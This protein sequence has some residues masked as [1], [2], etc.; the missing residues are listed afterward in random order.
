MRDRAFRPS[1]RALRTPIV[2]GGFNASLSWVRI[3]KSPPAIG[4]VFSKSPPV[5]NLGS[6]RKTTV[7][8]K[9]VP[10]KTPFLRLLGQ[11]PPQGL[12]SVSHEEI[13]C[14]VFVR[15]ASGLRLTSWSAF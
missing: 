11:E 7:F 5:A 8:G 1:A 2:E 15:H 4:F 9:L 10:Q 13:N 14:V 12:R 3:F 6:L